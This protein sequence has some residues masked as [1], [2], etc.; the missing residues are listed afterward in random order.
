[1]DSWKASPG[2]Q[3]PPQ[4]TVLISSLSLSLFKLCLSGLFKESLRPYGIRQAAEKGSS[5]GGTPAS[6]C[7]CRG[8]TW[9]G[10]LFWMWFARD[11]LCRGSDGKSVCWFDFRNTLR[12]LLVPKHL[13]STN[14]VSPCQPGSHVG[15]LGMFSSQIKNTVYVSP[16]EDTVPISWIIHSG[17]NSFTY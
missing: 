8:C 15:A 1:M 7:C 4:P 17:L 5:S 14:W 3:R 13:R 11:K 2:G 12:G 9:S 6:D 16:K 10:I